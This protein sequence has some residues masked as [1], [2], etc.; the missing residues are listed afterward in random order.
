MEARKTIARVIIPAV[1]IAIAGALVLSLFVPS[2]VAKIWKGYENSGAVL[3]ILGWSLVFKAVNMQLT[4]IMNS[5][6]KF[7]IITI[8]ASVNL[9][10]CVVFNI[11]F[12]QKFGIR[13]GAM[14]VV[15]VEAVNTITQFICVSYLMN[16]FIGKRLRE[17]RNKF[18]HQ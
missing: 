3:Q 13:G 7:R 8:I 10:M 18:K 5:L 17:W 9:A 2:L 6:G 4:A 15:L 14:T 1:G 16:N 11:I 12:L